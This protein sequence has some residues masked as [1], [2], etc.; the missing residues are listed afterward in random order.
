VLLLASIDVFVLSP[1][2]RRARLLPVGSPVRRD[3]GASSGSTLWSALALRSRGAMLLQ[4]S[5]TVGWQRHM[6]GVKSRIRGARQIAD[7]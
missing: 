1:L 7:S 4:Q 5:A 3:Y 6:Y 2:V